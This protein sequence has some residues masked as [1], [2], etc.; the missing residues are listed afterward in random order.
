MVL[1]EREVWVQGITNGTRNLKSV[2]KGAITS[3]PGGGPQEKCRLESDTTAGLHSKNQ[4]DAVTN[5]DDRDQGRGNMQEEGHFEG[6]L[7]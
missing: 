2:R 1:L 7:K 3:G 4:G 6:P 5:L